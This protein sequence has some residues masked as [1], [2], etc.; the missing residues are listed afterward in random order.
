MS[1]EPDAEGFA[2]RWSRLKRRGEPAPVVETAAEPELPVEPPPPAETIA[3]AEVAPWLSKRLPEGWRETVLRRVWSADEAIRDFKGLAD[4]A[5]DWSTPG[6]APG[7]GPML[8][9]DDIGKLLARAIGEVIPP[10]EVLPEMPVEATLTAE[11]EV[12]LS[13]AADI[14]PPPSI[15]ADEPHAN[16]RRRGG[17]AAP[18]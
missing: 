12:V 14:E 5:W 11:P 8:A 7:W 6:G 17:R 16:I 2:R 1:D 9:T 13:E 10:V 4:Y 3:L 18:V 15:E